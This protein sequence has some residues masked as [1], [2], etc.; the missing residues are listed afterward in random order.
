M[1]NNQN[2]PK[3]KCA[4]CFNIFIVAAVLFFLLIGG[5]FLYMEGQL[6]GVIGGPETPTPAPSSSSTPTLP[7]SSPTP[8]SSPSASLLPNADLIHPRTPMSGELV[9]SPLIVE[10]EAR[11]G[12]FF[13]ASFPVRLLDAN[14]KEITVTPA[15][16]QGEWT[17]ENFVPYKATL[18]FK[19]PT[20]DTGTLVLEKDN[21]SDLPENAKEVRIPVRFK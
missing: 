11:G 16:A 8:S 4:M 19:T 6:R 21:P 5:I 15:Q 3:Q 14:G 2:T 7:P 12:W 13:E 18:T 1:D 17:T 20:T 9:K 10:G